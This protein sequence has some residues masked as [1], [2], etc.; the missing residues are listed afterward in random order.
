MIR[1][2]FERLGV[3][4]QLNS[5][6]GGGHELLVPSHQPLTVKPDYHNHVPKIDNSI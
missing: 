1:L 6:E 2:V 4:T 5:L 3:Y